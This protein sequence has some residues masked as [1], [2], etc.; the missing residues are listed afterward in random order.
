MNP[1]NTWIWIIV[2]AGLFAAIFFLKQFGSKPAVR[3]VPVLPGFKGAAVVS[4]QVHPAGQSVIRAERTNAAWHLTKP[5]SYP[6][7]AISIESLLAALEQL[8]PVSQITATELRNRTN[9]DAEFG[10]EPP[11]VSLV[12][13]SPDT[14]KQILIG[15]RTAPGD[16]LYLQ[17]VGVGAYI[18]NADLLKVIPRTA[19][20]W[21]DTSFV[22]LRK[23]AFDRIMITNAAAVIELQR[24]ATNNSWTMR[25]ARADG[26]GITNLLQ[27][28]QALRVAQFLDDPRLDL[29]TFGL[30]PAELGLA[31]GQGTNVVALLQFGK[32][33][34]TNANLVYARQG[35]GT[36]VTVAKDLALPWR[37][38]PNKF[39]D[40]RLLTLTRPI[41]QIEVRSGESFTLQR[42]SN[43]TWRALSQDF[44]VDTGLVN[45]FLSGLAGLQIVQFKDAVTEQD[46]Q[47]DGLT[48]P[49][50]RQI[51]L[52]SAVTNALGPTNL[53]VAELSF[54]ATNEDAVFARRADENPVYL[55]KL[56]EFQQLPTAAWQLRAR[57]IGNFTTN[58]VARLTIRQG[59]KVRQLARDGTN[60]WALAPESQGIINVFA[61]EEIAYRF[62]ELAASTWVER[63]DQNLARYGLSTNGLALLFE[64]KNGEKLGVEFGGQSPSHYHYAATKLNGQTWVFEFP[65][66]LHELV[67]NYLTIPPDV[68]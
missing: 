23:L 53:V 19:D 22:D 57:R 46:L 44:P 8:M 45:D 47:A 7:Q 59:G 61:V 5:M 68:P 35:V 31:L 41:D 18:V 16:Q 2:A 34:A 43:N 58:N 9:A 56:A 42:E 48:N 12:I 10:F 49:P 37:D 3:P 4:V 60:S 66:G 64:L 36:I 1:K 65:L 32:S 62:G 39:R 40:R 67:L 52:R 15:T 54:G 50:P 20:D 55:V 51:I 29:E 6:A 38:V 17:V 13:E 33:P 27:K 21:R 63:G 28:L 14:R 24:D 11:H 25:G 30:Q 26:V